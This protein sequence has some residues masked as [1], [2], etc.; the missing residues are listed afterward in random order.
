MSLDHTAAAIVDAIHQIPLPILQSIVGAARLGEP[1][2]MIAGMQLAGARSMQ[3]P[4]TMEMQPAEISAMAMAC[5]RR[6]CRSCGKKLP[7]GRG[8]SG[9]VQILPWRRRP[10][11]GL[12]PPPPR[13]ASS[14][15]RP[16]SSP[17]VALLPPA[18][19][20]ASSSSARTAAAAA[21]LD[22]VLLRLQATT[23]TMAM[24]MDQSLT[25]MVMMRMMM[26][27]TM[28]TTAATIR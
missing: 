17:A 6:A 22:E 12:A 4:A 20:A 11:S 15:C 10:R 8:G 5:R 28:M 21:E 13:R 9:V 14:A 24:A 1:C 27:T 7:D 25:S 16:C 3:K 26:T 2:R 23:A 18:R 19:I